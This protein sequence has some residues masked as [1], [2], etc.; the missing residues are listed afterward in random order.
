MIGSSL[1]KAL[2]ITSPTGKKQAVIQDLIHRESAIGR[3]LFGAIP[4]DV[5]T[6]EFF[7]LD[8]THWIWFEEWKDSEGTM[9]RTVKYRTDEGAVVKSVNGSEYVAVTGAELNN[10]K[11]AARIYIERVSDTLYGT[12]L[13][14]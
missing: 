10:F 11:T 1:L 6:R 7:C 4:H 8:E 3:D 5:T 12:P 9:S 14:A 2:G 13:Y